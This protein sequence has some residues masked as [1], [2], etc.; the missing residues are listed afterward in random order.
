MDTLRDTSL[1]QE[2]IPGAKKVCLVTQG[3]DNDILSIVNVHGKLLGTW[4]RAA[5][6]IREMAGAD[7]NVLF[8][9]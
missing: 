5:L 1:V 3:D 6:C 2:W 7:T 4:E 8:T 9:R